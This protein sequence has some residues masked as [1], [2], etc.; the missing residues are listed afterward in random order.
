MKIR[1]NDFKHKNEELFLEDNQNP[2]ALALL[3]LSSKFIKKTE[4]LFKDE[5]N[6]EKNLLTLEISEQLPKFSQK[7][8]P[9]Q[10]LFSLSQNYKID[11]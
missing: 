3:Q 2:V 8:R 7:M 4:K 11:F 9:Y 1:S 10:T 6:F 5:K